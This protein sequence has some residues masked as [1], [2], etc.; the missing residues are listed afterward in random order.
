MDRNE[1]KRRQKLAISI[2]TSFLVMTAATIFDMYGN[3]LV[4]I[5]DGVA[6]MVGLYIPD[7]T[8]PVLVSWSMDMNVG[9]F[10]LTFDETVNATTLNLTD[11]TLQDGTFR[12]LNNYTLTG[13]FF[14][15]NDST[16]I[17]VNITQPPIGTGISD[18]NEL[19]RLTICRRMEDCFILH[20]NA[21]VYDMRHNPIQLRSN[22]QGLEVS[23]YIPD[24]NR[25]KL[26]SFETDL[27]KETLT[28][29]FNE[30]VN[31]S[32]LNFSAFALQDFFHAT[33]S[34]TLTHGLVSSNAPVVT[35]TFSWDD[36][37][38]I[39]RITEIF[40]S[41]QNSWITFTEYAIQDMA[42][43]PNKVI[44]CPDVISPAYL[45][46]I[47]F[48][49]TFIPDTVHPVLWSFDLN[50]TSQQLTLYFSETVR[51]SSLSISQ[52]TLQNRQNSSQVTQKHTLQIGSLPLFSV[53]DA[54]NGDYHILIVDLGQNDS[55]IIK[56]FPDLATNENNTFISF[57]KRNNVIPPELLSFYLDRDNGELVLT[58]SETV[59]GTSL[60]VSAITIQY[61]VNSTLFSWRLTSFSS[62]YPVIYTSKNGSITTS[63]STQ[64]NVTQ[65]NSTTTSNGTQF[66]VTQTNTTS[67]NATSYN[68]TQANVTGSISNGTLLNVSHTN[69]TS[70]NTTGLNVTQTNSSTVNVSISGLNLTLTNSTSNST[71][72]NISQPF[73]VLAYQM[74]LL[75][76]FQPFYTLTP[77]IYYPIVRIMLGFIDRNAI[78]SIPSLATNINNTYISFTSNAIVDMNVN[79][80]VAMP[81]ILALQASY[82]TPDTSPPQLVFFSLNLTSEVLSLT[83]NET[84][85]AS[86]LMPTTLVGLVKDM[87]GNPVIPLYNGMAQQVSVFTSDLIPPQL[88]SFGLDM[89]NGLLSLT[90]SETV[91]AT[92]FDVTQIVIQSGPLIGLDSARRLI[93]ESHTVPQ[94]GH[95]A[96]IND[97]VIIVQL[98]PSDLNRLKAT[99]NIVRGINDTWLNLSNYLVQD[100]NSNQV[101]ADIHQA[102][103]FIPDRTSPF[104]LSFSVNLIVDQMTLSFN[105]PINATT[106]NF[107]AITLQDDVTAQNNYTLTGGNIT[108]YNDSLVLILSFNAQDTVILKMQAKL[109]KSVQNT[110]LSFTS[111]AFYDTATVPNPV[112]PLVNMVNATMA[113][114]FTYYPAPGFVSVKPTAGRASGGTLVVVRGSNFGALWGQPGARP[115]DLRLDFVTA[116]NTTVISPDTVLVAVTPS[117]N[118]SKLGTPVTLTIVIDHSAVMLNVTRAYTYL[119][120]PIIHRV[121]PTAATAYGGTTITL[122]GQNFGPST[123]TGD[124]PDVNVF[125]GNDTCE[126]VTVV[127]ANTITCVL[128]SLEVQWYNVTVTVDTVPYTAINAIRTIDPPTVGAVSPNSA[129]RY[130][131]TAINV[132][133]TN[134]GPTTA[135]GDGNPLV[136]ELSTQF[137]KSLCTNV[138]VLVEDVL[139][140]CIAQPNLSPA[141]I[142]VY[143]DGVESDDSN[144]TFLY[145]DNAGS[146]SFKADVFFVSETQMYGTVTVVRHDYPPFA[147]PVWITVWAYDGTALPNIQFIASNQTLLLPYNE[148]ALNF[149][150]SITA[151]SYAMGKLRNGA[152]D[153][154]SVNLR[155]TNVS[156]VRGACDVARNQSVL[157]IKATCNVLSDV[158]IADW[159]LNQ[160]IYYR[161]DE[162][163]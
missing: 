59:N 83:F 142:T 136:V 13:G 154:V 159:N 32:S 30:T 112:V 116:L 121:F 44:P 137:G 39:K 48:T 113:T 69:M 147:S 109:V 73:N 98:G 118:I 93:S 27:T 55:D 138:T 9:S 78:K 5:A 127:D 129:F 14:T 86:S 10:V 149:S 11:L 34:Y 100:M 97:P 38:A 46:D 75:Q 131:P 23:G 3:A 62:L 162:L 94:L 139:L 24:T 89:N 26:L 120:P 126:S 95:T 91:N 145:Y 111:D 47:Y 117:P 72:L 6:I 144:V 81:N 88:V 17:P 105:E 140:T 108:K 96:I 2:S 160:V 28:F 67:V 22:G 61:E 84:V 151:A 146:V 76:V 123:S 133:G 135:S 85:N 106:V 92:S 52:I 157:V 87:S 134:F 19:K 8:P 21:T 143:V 42:F 161:L 124:G 64:F 156:P 41:Q 12:L 158:C 130:T 148:N 66:N 40:T 29:S 56:E 132:S 35:L 107:N 50:M 70:V 60:N 37:N 150:V 99:D 71:S 51:A 90:F 15:V 1:I 104:L 53:R 77:T 16:I 33:F 7:T 80:V 36:L 155:I 57:S 110:F 153:D 43:L 18:L 65:T 141:N 31:A 68:M 122:Y 45:T 114:H 102:D 152:D 103:Y 58:F 49:K 163:P 128:P 74:S 125:I 63:N 4:P 119:L 79:K 101:V 54:Y 20:L 82:V 115:V 25:P